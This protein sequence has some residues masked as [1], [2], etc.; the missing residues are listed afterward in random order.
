MCVCQASRKQRVCVAPRNI[1]CC[2]C[3]AVR[4][5]QWCAVRICV[6]VHFLI[7]CCVPLSASFSFS[8]SAFSIVVHFCDGCVCCSLYLCFEYVIAVACV[9]GCVCL[10]SYTVSTQCTHNNNSLRIAVPDCYNLPQSNCS[11]H[12]TSF[13]SFHS[14]DVLSHKED[15]RYWFPSNRNFKLWR[16][17]CERIRRCQVAWMRRV[18]L[19][20]VIAHHRMIHLDAVDANWIASQP[21][22]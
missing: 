12:F 6:L 8:C 17:R 4:I 14:F 9:C 18:N 3:C 7:L 15:C 19:L 22:H 2:C 21:T 5:C 13:Y 20:I 16:I 10:R 1:T 11:F